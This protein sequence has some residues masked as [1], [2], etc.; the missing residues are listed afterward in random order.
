VLR[1]VSYA[2]NYEGVLAQHREALN[3][4]VIWNI[5]FGLQ[6]EGRAVSA[7]YR[8]RGELFNRMAALLER[9]DVLICPATIVPPFP[10]EERYVKEAAGQQ[11]DTYIDWLSITYSVTMLGVPVLALPCGMTAD[12]LP[13]G[14]QI[15]GKPRG[16]A[17]LLS[18]ARAI[19]EIV[20]PWA[21][22]KPTR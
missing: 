11:F 8:T 10:V 5:E 3:P 15:V 19:E 13:V 16:E 1:G 12:G 6:L 17:A 4:D 21:T 20:G 9:Y 7:A 14:I 18:A 22:G 2:M